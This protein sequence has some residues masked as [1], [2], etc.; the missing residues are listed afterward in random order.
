[1][2]NLRL[3]LRAI[4]PV[5]IGDG[6]T[7]L[8]TDFVVRNGYVELVDYQEVLRNLPEVEAERLIELAGRAEVKNK[9]GEIYR[10][11][12]PV[13]RRMPLH[14]RGGV[15]SMK[16]KTCIR[17]SGGAYIPGSSLKGFIR[18]ALLYSFLKD[19]PA[20]LENSLR[21][22]IHKGLKY[23]R[24]R[25]FSELKK[26]KK[27]AAQE[28]EKRVFGKT[29]NTDVFR[30]VRIPDPKERCDT[31]VYEVKITGTR[32]S[33]PLYVEGIPPG[34]KFTFHIEILENSDV[35]KKFDGIVR[36]ITQ[37]M[38]L[39]SIKVFS[40]DLIE[41]EA[42]ISH[43]AKSFYNALAG[44]YVRLGGRTDYF[45]KTISLLISQST[46]REFRNL[47]RI[48]ENPRTKRLNLF[49]FPVTRS[50]TL[51]NKPLGWLEV[52]T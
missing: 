5:H 19:N 23:K 3:E 41:K 7:L 49:R 32:G 12:L 28:L 14:G 25:R 39:N 18:T 40:K 6:N 33:I 15:K 30:S 36:E 17:D 21:E 44:R 34:S 13:V 51:D 29:P 46:F 47:F 16:I 8:E 48:G 10:G 26:L 43:S 38:I 11:K 45:S 9:I 42:K 35:K 2:G 27:F 20:V 31:E 24:E 50:Y 22:V 52:V 37:D 4:T 1:M